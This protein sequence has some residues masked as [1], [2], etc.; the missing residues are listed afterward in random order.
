MSKDKKKNKNKKSFFSQAPKKSSEKKE[1]KTIEK[2]VK[3]VI[4]PPPP[5]P[6]SKPEVSKVKQ[7]EIRS[8]K[9]QGICYDLMNNKYCPLSR[10]TSKLIATNMVDKGA[11][12]FLTNKKFFSKL[13]KRKICNTLVTKY[14]LKP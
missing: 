3:E 12:T 11:S 9:I 1:E 10:A 8:Q 14:K 7:A 5:L 13:E 6:K 2:R 4:P